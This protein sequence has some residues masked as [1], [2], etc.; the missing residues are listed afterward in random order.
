M[1]SLGFASI[2]RRAWMVATAELA[3]LVRI[4]YAC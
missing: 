3:T 1:V 4:G 2:K